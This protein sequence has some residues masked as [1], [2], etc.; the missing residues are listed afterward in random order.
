MTDS[1]T[2]LILEN[3]AVLGREI[4]EGLKLAGHKPH[5]IRDAGAAVQEIREL[6]PALCLIDVD[7]T[8]SS[9]YDIVE[10]KNRDPKAAT[11]PVIFYSKSSTPID[12][13]KS[14][15]LSVRTYVSTAPAKADDVVKAAQGFFV[16]K[17]TGGVAAGDK[18]KSALAGKTV[19]WVEDDKFLA[20]ILT[21]KFMTAGCDIIRVPNGEEAFKVLKEKVPHAILLDVLLPGMN[22]FEIL[23]KIKM[24]SALRSIPVVILSNT[25]QSSDLEK[26]K[27]LG[28]SKF[29]VKAAVSLDEILREVG[30]LVK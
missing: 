14:A 22:G 3:D 24:D 30:T 1:K 6:N 21:K 25:S 15:G 26:S 13:R 10:A 12:G 20:D 5:L 16:E 9:G 7:L 27:M 17:S 2:I 8:T 4:L 11:S 23:Q 29:L 19:L 18:P 28:A